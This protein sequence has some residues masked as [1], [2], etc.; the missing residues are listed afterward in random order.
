MVTASAT[1]H[2]AFGIHVRPAAL[3]ARE[4][5]EYSGCLDLKAAGGEPVD[6]KNILG[7]ISLGLTSGQ[8]VEVRVDGPDEEKMAARLVELLEAHYDFPR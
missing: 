7:L 5:R 4:L 1:I 3:I 8:T 2:N 6:P